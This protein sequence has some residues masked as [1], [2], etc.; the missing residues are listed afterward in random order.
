MNLVSIFSNFISFD[1]LDLDLDK[2]ENFIKNL[3]SDNRAGRKLSNA[4]GWQSKELDFRN[5]ELSGLT[6]AIET[7]SENI[8][9]LLGIKKEIHFLSMWANVNRYKDY[10]RPHVHSKSLISGV[11]YIK[12]NTDSGKIVFEN[13]DNTM[14]YYLD[15]IDLDHNQFN[16]VHWAVPPE[17]NKLILFP[18]WL[19]HSV[20]PNLSQ[21]DRISI[22]FNLG[23]R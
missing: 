16:S 2:L 1:Y 14:R 21:E 8:K 23:V 9:Q 4:G 3:E 7:R 5:N 22:S 18:S 6:E 19:M 20:E 13:P 12:C 17:R 11:F 15:Q 10:N